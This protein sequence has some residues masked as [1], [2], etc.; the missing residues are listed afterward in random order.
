LQKNNLFNLFL[1]LKIN[2]ALLRYGCVFIF[3][4]FVYK[5]GA[6]VTYGYCSVKETKN[7]KDLYQLYGNTR[8]DCKPIDANFQQILLRVWI[9]KENVYDDQ[10]ILTKAKLYNENGKVIG[11]VLQDF[12]PFKFIAEIDTAYIFDLSGIISQACINPSSVP[13]TDLNKILSVAK[14]NA[15]IDTF[16][17][18]LVQFR[19]EEQDTD[20]KYQSFIIYE[21]NFILQKKEPRILIVFY[22]KELIAIFY[23]RNVIAKLYDSIE[24]GKEYKLIYNS[25]FT[26][27]TKSEMIQIFK[28]RLADI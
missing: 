7:G 17:T 6:E 3:C 13:E 21:P 16:F 25:K 26:E 28:K 14:Q 8:F 2:A 5:S 18:H 10:Q 20:Q 11:V 23:T 19:Y 15:K 24:M 12:T 27:H 22:K 1:Y 4:I 9:K